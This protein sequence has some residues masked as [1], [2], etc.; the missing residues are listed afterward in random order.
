[1]RRG[2]QW[3]LALALT[4]GSAVTLGAQQPATIV[5]RVTDRASGQPLAAA[6][7]Q[8]VGTT[9]G[10]ATGDDGRYRIAGVPA[11]Q[12]QVR[13]LRIGYR[14]VTRPVTAV[15]GQ[16][17]TADFALDASAVTLDQVVV[18]ATGEQIRRREQGNA[19]SSIQPSTEEQAATTNLTDVLNSRTPGVYVQQSSGG[20]GTG[21]RIRIRGANSL[22]LSNE[23]LLVVDGIRANNTVGGPQGTT[24]VGTGGQVISRLND[25]N[26]E[27]IESIEVIKGPAGVAIY[28]TAA[29]NGVIQITTKKGRSGRTAWSGYLEGGTLSQDVTIPP[30]YG[31]VG[32]ATSNGARVGCSLDA[33]TR[34]V[35][36]Q[37]ELLIRNPASVDPL[38]RD[39]DRQAIGLNAAG[40]SERLTYFVGGDFQQERGVQDV[41][42]D[43]RMNLRANFR[44]ELRPSWDVTVNSGYVRDYLQLPVNDNSTIGYMGVTMLGRANASDTLSGGFLNNYTPTQLKNIRVRQNIDRFL[45]SATTNYQARKWLSF[46]GVAGWTSCSR[47]ASRRSSRTG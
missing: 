8:I 28:G 3:M 39:G 17:E 25:I 42:N 33:V 27:D 2:S 41:N 35:C 12:V 37:T 1:M 23:P 10:A 13:V 15:A 34:G 38:F 40:G 6:Q 20:T 5:G 45:S 24:N 44:G 29:A 46:S 22:S 26:P 36:R 21:S 32:T 31:A 18:T 14:A 30:N 16:T 11:G 43:R 4:A 7:V 47:R 19:V 9:R